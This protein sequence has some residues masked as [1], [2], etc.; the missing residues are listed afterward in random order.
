MHDIDIAHQPLGTVYKP[1]PRADISMRHSS[2]C[3]LP[4]ADFM[5]E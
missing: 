2:F 4:S 5:M 3:C 1:K